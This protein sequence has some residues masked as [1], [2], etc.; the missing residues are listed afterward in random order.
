MTSDI[1]KQHPSLVVRPTKT[2]RHAMQVMTKTRVGIVL[3]ADAKK[4]LL[5]LITDI[6]IRRAILHGVGVDDPVTKVMN[7]KPITIPATATQDQIAEFFRHTPRAFMPIV[8][9]SRR[10]VS[11]AVMDQYATIPQHYPN[12]VVVMAGGMGKRL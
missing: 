11:L 12:W 8:D 9:A 1:L 10:L 7:P 5:G 2:L 4:R 3:V 6:D